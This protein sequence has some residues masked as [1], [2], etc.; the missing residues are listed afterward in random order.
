MSLAVLMSWSPGGG[1]DLGADLAREALEDGHHVVEIS[2]AGLEEEGADA[3]LA[4]APDVVDDLLG[5]ALERLA[6][7]AARP[8]AER[9]PHAERDREIVDRAVGLRALGAE[10]L[11]VAG[12]RVGRREGGVPAV[13]QLRDAPEG[14]RRVAAHPDG[15]TLARGLRSDPDLAEGEELAGMARPLFGPARAHDADGLVGPGAAPIV[16]AAEDLDLL[17]HPADTDPQH[18]AALRQVIE[19]G[20]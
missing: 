11:H 2:I 13:A 15:D 4:I 18:H 20:D 19:G 14:A 3:Q 10:A 17:A 8:C 5:C 16:V 12:E 1:G 9:E 6:V 7:G